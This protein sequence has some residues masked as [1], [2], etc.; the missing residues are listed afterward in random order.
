MWLQWG[1]R[2]K[3]KT[4]G[5]ST[6]EPADTTFQRDALREYREFE[7]PEPV[8]LGDG[9]MVNALGAGKVKMISQLIPG[10]K[11]TGWMTEVLYVPKLTSNLFS[12][13]F[14]AQ[15]GNVV[16]FGHENCWIR[17]RKRKLIGTGSSLGKLYKLNCAVLKSPTEKAKV[18]S[19]PE[20]RSK[21]ELWHRR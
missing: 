20:T 6:L 10:R 21:T 5:S 15:K 8:Q 14:A 16:S 18:A 13:H 1:S 3:P 2:R 12:V 7:Y 4:S 17:N 19:G 9:R 11:V